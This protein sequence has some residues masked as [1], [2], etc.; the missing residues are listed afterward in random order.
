MTQNITID[1]VILLGKTYFEMCKI[2]RHA[3]AL[4]SLPYFCYIDPKGLIDKL[5]KWND[6]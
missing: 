2:Y 4:N 1:F 3:G 6:F 5:V